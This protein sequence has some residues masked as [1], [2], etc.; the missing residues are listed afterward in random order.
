[1]F[2]AHCP[3]ACQ[4]YDQL[5]RLIP[6]IVS[7]VAI[8]A[9]LV[10]AVIVSAA[11]GAPKLHSQQAR[12]PSVTA[13]KFFEPYGSKGLLA[14]V[15]RIGTVRGYCWTGSLAVRDSRAWRCFVGNFILDPCFSSPFVPHPSSVACGTPW[16]GVRILELTRPLPRSQAN[17]DVYPSAGGLLQLSN[18]SRC[19]IAQ[20][21]TG[22][23]SGVPLAYSCTGS[24]WAGP[25]RWSSEP[26]WV[27]FFAHGSQ[28]PTRVLVSV[29][30]GG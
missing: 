9:L 7:I 23:K 15:R 13:V 8:I 27:D 16:S 19:Q 10:A 20:G 25:L 17:T 29:A 6:R 3:R 1:M 26:W 12:P 24:T 22:S 30:W 4:N 2:D 28:R 18:G 5:V 11:A 21:A 14:S